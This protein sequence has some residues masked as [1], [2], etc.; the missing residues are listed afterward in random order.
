LPEPEEEPDDVSLP[1]IVARKRY[2]PGGWYM[3]G[4][5]TVLADLIQGAK[6]ESARYEAQVS[7]EWTR[8]K[9]TYRRNDFALAV[10]AR[11][12]ALA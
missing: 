6:A 1:G 2:L 3:P 8:R 12:D 7:R 10:K 5:N 11:K 9:G 4:F